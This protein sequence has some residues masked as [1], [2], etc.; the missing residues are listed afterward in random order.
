M[1]SL[2]PRAD[3]LIEREQ[4]TSALPLWHQ[5]AV[6]RTGCSLR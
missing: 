3:K 2:T 1:A 6:D 5:A 4:C